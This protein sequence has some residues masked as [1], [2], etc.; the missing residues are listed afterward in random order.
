MTCNMRLVYELTFA[1]SSLGE[2]TKYRHIIPTPRRAAHCI[3]Y[4]TR[5]LHIINESS[6]EHSQWA[7]VNDSGRIRQ[8]KPGRIFFR[9]GGGAKCDMERLRG[10]RL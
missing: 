8:L 5:S 2:K 7:T 6:S 9:E 1:T 3:L 4:H 10:L